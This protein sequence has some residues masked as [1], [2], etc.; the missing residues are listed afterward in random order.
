MP[1]P[2]QYRLRFAYHSTSI[3]NLPSVIDN[4]LLSTNQKQQ[5]NIT[6]TDIANIQI[7]QRR[8]AMEVPESG[9]KCVH[10]YVPFYFA[11]KTP[12]LLAV[13]NKKN[14]DQE[15]LIYFAL[16]LQYIDARDGVV[17]TNAS[18]N[19]EELPKFYSAN[20]SQHL[21]DL[22]WNII[23]DGTW[24]YNDNDRRLKMAE[25]LIPDSIPIQA[26]NHIIVWDDTVANEV[27]RIFNSK[28]LTPPQIRPNK[29][30]YYI[31][32]SAPNQPFIAGPS[33]LKKLFED[34]VT[35]IIRDN[36]GTHKYSTLQSAL[37][38]IATDFCAIKELD[39]ING[40]N[41]DYGPHKDDVG[42]HSRRVA[43]LV[44]H[45]DEYLNLNTEDQMVLELAA[46]LHDI[47]KGPKSRWKDSFMDK[48]DNNH[49]RKSL[50]M[51]YRIITQ[52]IGGLSE[53]Q[54]RTL[55]ML[56][57]YDDLL[58]DIAAN[59][60][61]RQQLFDIITCEKD[62]QMLVALSKADIGAINEKWLTNTSHIIDQLRAEA[63]TIITGGK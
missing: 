18:A 48:A 60:R 37:Q 21:D 59:G 27:E 10:D 56:V 26:F 57:T 55:T 32:F 6:H 31:D 2:K 11:Q 46:L 34:T 13:I 45:S 43:S 33:L 17:F 39:D 1:I 4:G 47:G 28:K 54:V 16:S 38:A 14:T 22:S 42:K 53:D 12:M 15:N 41:A 35:E 51:L 63:V 7:Q 44:K 24:S 36:K 8:S 61:D 9:G 52:D 29:W 30:H 19:G 25:L 50:P 20:Q 23:N 40:L 3:K 62:I 49:P 5:K 58:G